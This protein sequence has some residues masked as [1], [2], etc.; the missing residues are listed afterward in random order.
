MTA[1]D[2][3]AL[4]AVVTLIRPGRVNVTTPS[5]NLARRRINLRKQLLLLGPV[6]DLGV[7]ILVAVTSSNPRRLFSTPVLASS[8]QATPHAAGYRAGHDT[9]WRPANSDTVQ[10]RYQNCGL[11]DGVVMYGCGSAGTGTS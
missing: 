10:L 3:L 6:F 1:S 4:A 7:A 2:Q 5:N 8:G 11:F 9:R